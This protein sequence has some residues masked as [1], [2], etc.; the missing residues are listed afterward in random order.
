MGATERAYALLIAARAAHSSAVLRA[1]SNLV[2][3]LLGMC[4]QE[5]Q[6]DIADSQAA[7]TYLQQT[8]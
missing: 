1:Y 8:Y 4:E 5:A 7:M 2:W 3:N 6:E